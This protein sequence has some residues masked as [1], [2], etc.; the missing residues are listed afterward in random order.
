MS[1]TYKKNCK[2]WVFHSCLSFAKVK[3]MAKLI[4]WVP[5]LGKKLNIK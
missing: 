5:G 2:H 1:V 4:S 3:V